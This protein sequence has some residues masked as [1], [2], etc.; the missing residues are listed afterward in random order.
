MNGNRIKRL[1]SLLKEVL[2]DVIIRE[3]RNPLV[4]KL[5][6]V[7][8]VEVTRDLRQARVY[9]SVIGSE[10]ER[11]ETIKGLTSAGGYISSLASKQVAIRYF[12]SLSFELDTTVD[13]Q[14]QIECALKKI[15]KEKECRKTQ[16]LP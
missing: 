4:A 10:K 13:K 12:P 2:S 15:E 5:V 14:M 7:T 3:V 16:I 11:L 1:N 9:V 6:G 8:H